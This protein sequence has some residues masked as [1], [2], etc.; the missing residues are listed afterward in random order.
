[1]K[2]YEPDAARVRA[3]YRLLAPSSGARTLEVCF[4]APPIL[5]ADDWRGE[6][7][8]VALGAPTRSP[9]DRGAEARTRSAHVQW[10]WQMPEP[11]AFDLVVLHRTLDRLASVH[12]SACDTAALEALFASLSTLLVPRGVLVVTVANGGRLARWRI[13][14]RGG[15]SK[16]TGNGGARLSW[17]RLR[18]LFAAGGFVDVQSYNVLPD[19]DAPLR[20][21]NT[22]ADLSR[23]GF[24][25]E[26]AFMQSS[27]PLPSYLLRRAITEVALN[28]HIEHSLLASGARP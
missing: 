4:G 19:A 22:D 13:A 1:L 12:S 26:L 8:V 23:V 15:T 16:D 20:L 24:R 10:Q 17:A 3:M 5:A 25:R 2:P 18:R 21:V 7:A 14:H 27:L 9:A 28:R 6:H 11:G